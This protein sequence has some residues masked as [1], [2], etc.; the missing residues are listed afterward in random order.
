MIEEQAVTLRDLVLKLTADY[1]WEEKK[2]QLFYCSLFQGWK[3][4]SKLVLLLLRS[5]QSLWREKIDI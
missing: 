1:I 3:G 4:Q 5:V 2:E